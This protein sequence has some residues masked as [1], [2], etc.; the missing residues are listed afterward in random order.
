MNYYNF[1][2]LVVWSVH[3]RMLHGGVNN[4]LNFIRNDYWLCK[5]RM[6]FKKRMH[7]NVYQRSYFLNFLNLYCYII[8]I[9][10]LFYLC[11]HGGEVFMRDLSE[12]LKTLYERY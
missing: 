7:Q 1:T 8:L 5:K 2:G 11:L 10:N 12:Q 3:K 6:P 9:G 4:T